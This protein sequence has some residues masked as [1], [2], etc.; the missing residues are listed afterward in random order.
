MAELD[1]AAT[2]T[3][4]VPM[5]NAKLVGG[6]WMPATERHF[7]EMMRPG[8]KRHAIRDGKWTYQTHKLDTAMRY[9]ENRRVCIDIG[10]HVGL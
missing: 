2:A 1:P 9:V 6:V 8:A 3:T 7:V 4:E 5:A 10:A